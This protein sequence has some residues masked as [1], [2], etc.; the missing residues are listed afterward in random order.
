MIQK[1]SVTEKGCVAKYIFLIALF[2][3]TMYNGSVLSV[4]ANNRFYDRGSRLWNI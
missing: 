4:Y 1:Q 3:K 2:A